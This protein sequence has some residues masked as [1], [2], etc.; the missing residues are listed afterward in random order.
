MSMKV[1]DEIGEACMEG[2]EHVCHA[3]RGVGMCL[4][5]VYAKLLFFLFGLL[6][7]ACIR[8]TSVRIR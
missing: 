6:G 1:F 2:Q 4:G 7:G 8:T 5:I 3:A